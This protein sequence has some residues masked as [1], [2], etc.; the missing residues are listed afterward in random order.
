MGA[1]TRGP[2]ISTAI[3]CSIFLPRVASPLGRGFLETQDMK[4]RILVMLA[5]I[6]MS[7]CPARADDPAA[8]VELTRRLELLE[9]Q[10][11]E[12]RQQLQSMQ[13]QEATTP[14]AEVPATPVAMAND[15][16][17]PAASPSPAPAAKEEYFTMDEIR[18]EMKKLQWT[19]GDFKIVPY[20]ILWGS[21]IWETQRTQVGDYT[22]FVLPDRPNTNEQ[23]HV[24][25]RSTRLGIDVSGPQVPFFNCAGS[26]GKVEFDFQR[27]LDTENRSGVL[28]RHAYVEV[29]NEDF[30]L[31]FGQTWDV[32]S[33]LYPGMLMYSVG[34][35]GGNL[36]YRRAQLRGEKY[37]DVADDLLVT[38]QG[39][40]NGDILN[41]GDLGSSGAAFLGDQA[42]WPVLMS[43]VGVTLG[44]RGPGCY[45]IE[46][47]ASGHIGEQIFDFRGPLFPAM[48]GVARKTWSVNADF[49]M[50][51]GPRFGV[52]GE[53]F[54]GAN[55]GAYL[56]GA[57]Q[58]I[59][60]G[61]P[62]AGIAGSLVPIRSTG[63]WF[64]VWYDWTPRLHSH[65]GYSI[66]DPLDRDVTTGRLYNA[67]YFA[68]L[69]YDLTAKF[70]VGFE[71]SQWKTIWEPQGEAN[72]GHFEL[73]AKYAF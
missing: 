30:R 67:F 72:S 61:S 58:G 42:G 2:V 17:Q 57:L 27:N 14:P 56:G 32:I 13:Q 33:P 71:Y 11:Q 46:L 23:F 36:G 15:M 9:T 4:I 69:S 39:S 5:C 73:A 35:G 25:G 3:V 6:L 52:Q 47:G 50:P 68:N 10:T 7:S 53:F 12:L 16:A 22:F 65:V 40:L 51:L 28:L 18:G 54:T 41:T 38:V 62:A 20:G 34:W 70:L 44:Q 21:A 8:E 66:D 31:L 29:K 24:D 49:R 64:D 45:P 26:G 1:E 48:T 43:R 55:L 60:I 59:D 37:F 19:K 63:G